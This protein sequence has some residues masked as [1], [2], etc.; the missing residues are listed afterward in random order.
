MRMKGKSFVLKSVWFLLIS[1]IFIIAGVNVPYDVE[2]CDNINN[3]YLEEVCNT[4]VDEN[5][6][7]FENCYEQIIR[8]ITRVCKTVTYYNYDSS[9]DPVYDENELFNLVN[10]SNFTSYNDSLL[11]DDISDIKANYAK[12]INLSALKTRALNLEEEVVR[13]NNT[14]KIVK[15]RGLVIESETCNKIP[16]FNWTWCD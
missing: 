7:E 4:E 16:Q 8:N 15:E 14:L 10:N 12:N 6:L 1:S 2:V 13:L 3:P 5:G 11:V 9:G